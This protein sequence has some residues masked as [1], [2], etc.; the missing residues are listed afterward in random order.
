MNR[1]SRNHTSPGRPGQSGAAKAG[2][3][4]AQRRKDVNGNP[5][6]Q[7][8]KLLEAITDLARLE[9]LAER[10]RDVDSW[11]ELLADINR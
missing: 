11:T 2:L 8:Q 6:K 9:T 1:S 4:L 7:Q 5:P 10:L 3:G